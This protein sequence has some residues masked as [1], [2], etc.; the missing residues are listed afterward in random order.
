VL[1]EV[2][3]GNDSREEHE[4][5]ERQKYSCIS[6]PVPDGCPGAGENS[7]GMA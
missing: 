6:I 5:A 2:S 1:I 4:V 3:R 7:R